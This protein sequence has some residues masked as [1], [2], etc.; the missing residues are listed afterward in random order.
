MLVLLMCAYASYAVIPIA[1]KR[2]TITLLTTS[3]THKAELTFE[4][5]AKICVLM[6]INIAVLHVNG[7]FCL[8]ILKNSSYATHQ[9]LTAVYESFQL[10][11]W[12]PICLLNGMISSD[13]MYCKDF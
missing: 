10:P 6:L 1:M 7:Y 3:L 5:T 2:Q 9:M 8:L 11:Q 4:K 13:L 12:P